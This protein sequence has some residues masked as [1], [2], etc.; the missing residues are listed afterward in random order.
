MSQNKPTVYLSFDIEADGPSPQYN[1]ML[2]IG[3]WGFNELGEEIVAWERNLFPRQGKKSDPATMLEFW[4]KYP[5][6]WKYVN[7]NKVTTTTAF[8]ELHSILSK[9]QFTY[10][11]EWLAW[12]ASFDWQWL[13]CYYQD[14]IESNPEVDWL[15]LAHKATCMSSVWSFYVKQQKLTKEAENDLWNKFSAGDGGHYALADAKCQG[16]LYYNLMKHVGVF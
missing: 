6:A 13:N 4:A 12:P 2:S 15:K 9:L 11:I 1:N 8:T 10:R 3:V 5:D 16:Q 7:T 14:F